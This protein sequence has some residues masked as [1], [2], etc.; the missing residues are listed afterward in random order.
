MAQVAISLSKALKLKNRLAGRLSHVQEL[1][2]QHNTVLKEQVGQLDVP[3]LI[4]EREEIMYQLVA[5]KTAIMRG[6]SGIQDAIIL[7]GELAS[8][9]E[10]LSGLNTTD[11]K[12]RH[13]YQNTDMEYVATIKKADVEKES[14]KLEKQIDDLQD[15]ID[16][17]NA[18]KKIEIDQRALDLAS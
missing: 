15:K 8:T 11:G 12:L 1:V 7:K 6:N 14:R 9:K 16:E 18:T 2:T 3:A 13:G 5:L 17:Y 10:W 4:K